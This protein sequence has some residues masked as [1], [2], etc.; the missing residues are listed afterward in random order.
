MRNL[1]SIVE[2]SFSDARDIKSGKWEEP[3]VPDL[4]AFEKIRK[5]ETWI[6]SKGFYRVGSG[7]YGVVFRKADSNILVKVFKTTDHGYLKYIDYCRKNRN[8]PHVPRVSK[9]M[10][11]ENIAFVFIEGLKSYPKSDIIQMVVF[12]QEH[13]SDEA[14]KLSEKYPL[15]KKT[16]ADLKKIIDQNSS[17]LNN[18]SISLDLYNPDNIMSRNGVP[19]IID[20]FI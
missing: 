1:I 4:F 15:F 3:Y 18:P 13:L 2:T 11:F 9:P 16:I 5:F 17:N 6:K 20:P 12:D 14:M 10:F 8:N 7:Y 19:V